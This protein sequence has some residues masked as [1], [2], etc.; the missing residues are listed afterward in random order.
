MSLSHVKEDITQTL[1]YLS[2]ILYITNE[3]LDYPVAFASNA[4]YVLE[5]NNA[6][7]RDDYE[8]TLLPILRKK[9]DYLHAEGVA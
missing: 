6:S 2:K 9:I 7:C 4:L 8:K 3:N 5:R 1:P